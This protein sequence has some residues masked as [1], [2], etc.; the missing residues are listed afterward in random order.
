MSH[1]EAGQDRTNP[2]IAE[3]STLALANTIVSPQNMDNYEADI[4]ASY[5]ARQ[6]FE[7]PNVT[8][9]EYWLS[10]TA[11]CLIELF[12]LRTKPCSAQH[13]ILGKRP[14]RLDL[15]VSKDQTS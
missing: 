3:V 1:S 9:G 15:A 2:D 4:H 14:S 7:S 11:A 12:K 10:S 8:I 5:A 13:V 6:D